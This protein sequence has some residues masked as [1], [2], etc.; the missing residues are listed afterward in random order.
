MHT[1]QSRLATSLRPSQHGCLEDSKETKKWHWSAALP[2]TLATLGPSR[3]PLTLVP[4]VS[5][6]FNQPTMY[7]HSFLYVHRYV[8][9]R[10]HSHHKLLRLRTCS[11]TLHSAVRLRKLQSATMPMCC[12]WLPV[13]V[14][15]APGAPE[16]CQLLLKVWH[17]VHDGCC[18][19]E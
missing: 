12:S 18:N 10:F 19:C 3:S 2:V 8:R 1:K 16:C 6:L 7:Q 5:G 14:C 11:S 4:P 13:P 15:L 17:A 9:A